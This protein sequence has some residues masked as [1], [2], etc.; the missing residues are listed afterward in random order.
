MQE[1]GISWKLIKLFKRRGM[2]MHIILV[3]FTL[4]VTE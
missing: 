4:Y 2:L 1:N 3:Q